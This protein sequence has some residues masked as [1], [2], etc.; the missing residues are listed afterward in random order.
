MGLFFLIINVYISKMSD[1]KFIDCIY[2]IIYIYKYY[3]KYFRTPLH[4][5][6]YL[7]IYFVGINVGKHVHAVTTWH[8]L[9][10]LLLTLGNLRLVHSSSRVSDGVVGLILLSSMVQSLNCCQ[11]LQWPERTNGHEGAAAAVA[12]WTNAGLTW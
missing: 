8:A 3:V 5:Y 9:A 12:E 10:T 7:F 4:I 2:I 11:H 6:L 1:R